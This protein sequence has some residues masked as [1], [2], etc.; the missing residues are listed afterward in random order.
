MLALVAMGK[1]QLYL[2]FFFPK[3]CFELC[4]LKTKNA[5]TSHVALKYLFF[6]CEVLLTEMHSMAYAQSGSVTQAKLPVSCICHS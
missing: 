2:V 6:K 5:E 3:R 1:S 4:E